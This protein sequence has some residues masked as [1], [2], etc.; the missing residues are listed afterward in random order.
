MAKINQ[1]ED[2]EVWKMAR[3]ICQQVDTGKSK[4]KL[5]HQIP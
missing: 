4:N 3:E 5:I 1:F 2:L